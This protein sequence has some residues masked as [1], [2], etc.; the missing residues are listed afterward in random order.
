MNP[1]DPAALR[2]SPQ[3][4]ERQLGEQTVLLDLRAG[5]YFELDATGS[6]IWALLSEGRSRAD[7]LAT[8]AAEYDAAPAVL[9]AD[10]DRLL[11]ELLERGL[12]LRGLDSP[13][14]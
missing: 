8:L 11:A 9:A 14:P 4:V 1:N 7:L 10:V 5:R 2:I 6:R 3:V 13:I 12:V